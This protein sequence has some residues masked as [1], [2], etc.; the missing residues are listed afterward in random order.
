MIEIG[1][2]TGWGSKGNEY[3]PD[4]CEHGP[5]D[6][7]MWC[8]MRCNTDTHRCPGCGTVTDHKETVCCPAC[9]DCRGCST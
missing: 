8:C 2:Y 6:G 7:C 9:P 3:R 1:T 4:R 5:D